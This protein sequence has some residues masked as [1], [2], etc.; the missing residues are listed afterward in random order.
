M[1]MTCGCPEGEFAG[2]GRR[3]ERGGKVSGKVCV[4]AYVGNVIS[5]GGCWDG[6]FNSETLY[7]LERMNCHCIRTD[8]LAQCIRFLLEGVLLWLSRKVPVAEGRNVDEISFAH[9][10]TTG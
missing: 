3:V 2:K 6:R 9:F 4:C 1:S 10:S 8:R 5:R 7:L